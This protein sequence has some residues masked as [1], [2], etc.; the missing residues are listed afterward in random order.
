VDF[1]EQQVVNIRQDAASFEIGL[2]KRD[3]EKA[4]HAKRLNFPVLF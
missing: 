3:G 2:E 1:I 4:P